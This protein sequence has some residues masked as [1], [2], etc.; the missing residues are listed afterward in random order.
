MVLPG[1]VFLSGWLLWISKVRFWTPSDTLGVLL[2]TFVLFPL[3]FM[4][5]LLVPVS[6]A[7]LFNTLRTNGVIGEHRRHQLGAET[8]ENFVQ[9]LI[10]WM[11]TSWWTAATLVILVFYVCYRLLLIEPWIS[12]P[13]PYWF[14]VSVI[15]VYLPLMYAVFLSVVRLLLTLV[16][17][18]W[19][20]SLFMIQIKPLH[21]DGSGG[22]GALGRILWVSIIIM[23]WNALV[24]AVGDQHSESFSG[25]G[26]LACALPSHSPAHCF[27]DFAC[28]S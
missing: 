17:T 6:I 28:Q 27:T 7:S 5:Y 26:D 13:V 18:N 11:D 3:L 23:L 10:T 4:I 25:N 14:R 12:S 2:L 22:L 15:V 24:L 16:F 21:P 8:Y 9:Q 19:L 20:F 1:G